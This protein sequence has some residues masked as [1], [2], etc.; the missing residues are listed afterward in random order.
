VGEIR[1]KF[2]LAVVDIV[3]PALKVGVG[4]FSR[5]FRCKW[6]IKKSRD[7]DEEEHGKQASK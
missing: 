3:G 6:G 2:I 4:D 1:F 5:G 7:E